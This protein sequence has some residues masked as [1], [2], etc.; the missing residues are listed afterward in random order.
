MDTWGLVAN[1]MRE[2]E[3]EREKARERMR[4]RLRHKYMKRNK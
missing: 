2:R 4:E 1:G 3:G